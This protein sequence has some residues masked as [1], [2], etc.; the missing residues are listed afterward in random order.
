MKNLINKP[1]Y[2]EWLDSLG[3]SPRWEIIDD[4]IE[5]GVVLC[6]TLGFLIKESEEYILIIP[7]LAE[8]DENRQGCGDMMICKKQIKKIYEI[9]L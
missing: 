1:V 8:V 3:C 4:D 9:S 5:M 6:K 7:H 2:V